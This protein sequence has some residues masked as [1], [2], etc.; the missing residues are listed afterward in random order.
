MPNGNVFLGG[1]NGLTAIYNP[2]TNSWSE[3][4]T[5]PSVVIDGVSTQLT[6][7]DAPGSVMPNGD[8][9]LSL[10][11]AV[12]APNYPGP[13]YIYDF[14][15]TTN[16]YTDLTPQLNT[17][18]F[19]LGDNSF[20]DDMLV[21]PTGQMWLTNFG[22][23]PV[24]SSPIATG[25][26]AWKPTITSFVANGQD[27]FTLTGTQLNGLNEGAEYGDD[28]QMAENYPIVQVTDTKTGDVYYATTSDWSSVGVADGQHSETVTVVLPQ[29]LGNDPYRLVVIAD[30]IASNSISGGGLALRPRPVTPSYSAAATG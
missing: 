18:G 26:P 6:M 28:N 13:T 12:Q 27:D 7:G 30:G 16:V 21:L 15:P 4:P 8:L 20:V 23:D 22:G 2:A 11:P 3:G 19:Y 5:M 1:A 29:A 25:N 14:N 17:V 10:S 24:I 9:L